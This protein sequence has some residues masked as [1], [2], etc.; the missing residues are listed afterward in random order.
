MTGMKPQ[1]ECKK[2]KIPMEIVDTKTSETVI[3]ANAGEAVVVSITVW[4]CQRCKMKVRTATE[5]KPS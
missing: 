3:V 4:R 2:C 1:R 5:A